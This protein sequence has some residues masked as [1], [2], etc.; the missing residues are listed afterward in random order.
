MNN[1][2]CGQCRFFVKHKALKDNSGMCLA[3]DFRVSADEKACRSDFK[4]LKCKRQKLYT[5]KKN[6]DL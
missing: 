2:K 1:K 4:A 6:L 3:G 5:Q